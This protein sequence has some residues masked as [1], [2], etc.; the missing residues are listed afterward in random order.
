MYIKVYSISYLFNY[1]VN[2]LYYC[3]FIFCPVAAMS[4]IFPYLKDNIGILTDII[5]PLAN[6]YFN[7]F[8]FNVF[9]FQAYKCVQD[10]L[11]F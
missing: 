2:F 9:K 7:G 10:V 8:K 11:G 1:I 5:I 3:F 4:N 6:F